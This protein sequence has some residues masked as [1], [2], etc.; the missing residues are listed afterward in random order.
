[1]P[2][3]TRTPWTLKRRLTIT[4]GGLLALAAVLIG[5]V[6]V[7]ALR[8][9]LVERLDL[10]LQQTIERSQAAVRDPNRHQNNH[11][12]PD[13]AQGA[14]LAPGQ[15][16]G[17]LVAV[18]TN[19]TGATAGLLTKNGDIDVIDPTALDRLTEQKLGA[20]PQSITIAGVGEYRITAVNATGGEKLVIG[21]P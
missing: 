15:Q 18:V 5:L 16:A 10:Q 13:R 1:M 3:N 14:L 9:F 2:R 19:K 17:T 11:G 20:K 8:G 4:V 6:S 12:D 7:I 21:L